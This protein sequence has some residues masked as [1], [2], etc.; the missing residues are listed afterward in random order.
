M[1]IESLNLSHVRETPE[2]LISG[3][4]QKARRTLHCDHVDSGGKSMFDRVAAINHLRHGRAV[5]A[6]TAD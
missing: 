5:V 2:L 1:M 6:T 3:A 4:T